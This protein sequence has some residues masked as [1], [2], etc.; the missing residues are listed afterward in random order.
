MEVYVT[1]IVQAKPEYQKEVQAFLLH[2]VEEARKEAAC[3]RYDLHQDTTDENRFVFY[4]IW[5]NQQGLD[6]HN[7]QPYMG[8]LVEMSKTHFQQSPQI[9]LTHK[10]EYHGI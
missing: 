5:E 4:E 2:L 1:A 8:E 10:I 9:Y 6:Q 7:Q 3:V